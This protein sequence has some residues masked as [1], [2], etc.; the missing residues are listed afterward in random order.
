MTLWRETLGRFPVWR[1]EPIGEGDDA[2]SYPLNID[3]LPADELEA[4]GLW[5][6]DMIAPADAIPQGKIA[7]GTGVERVSGVV[8]FVQEL[9]DQPKP[10]GDQINAE[11]DRRIAAGETFDVSGYG[12]VP[13]QGRLQDQ[14][15]LQARLLAAQAAKAA[16]VST[17]VLVIRDAQNVN[18][19]L[20]PDQIIELV[21]AGTAWIEAIMLVSWNMK[22][23]V[24]PFEAG[25]P[26]DYADDS[27][28]D[29]QVP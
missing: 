18:H 19:M 13:L 1:G 12:S 24:A 21:S 28:W 8:S 27:Y 3:I 16:G 20:T 4:V 2:I 10:T 15:N 23:G 9:A 17:P 6:D 22:D 11:R 26:Y 14:V 5:R 25:P 29:V 7:V